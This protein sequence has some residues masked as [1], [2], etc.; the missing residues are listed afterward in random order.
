LRVD[1]EEGGKMQEMVYEVNP[2]EGR[3]D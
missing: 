2:A 3:E 1:D